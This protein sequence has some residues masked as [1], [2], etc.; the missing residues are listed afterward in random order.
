MKIINFYND[1]QEREK[2]LLFI[3]FVLI[4]SLVLYFI[5]SGVHS[6]YTRSS[7]NLEKAKSDY[8]YVLNKIQRIQNSY[9][10][11]VLDKNVITKL[12]SSNNFENKVNNLQISST[13]KLIYVTFTTSNINDA[14]SVT[15]K[16][17]NGS[18]NQISNIRYQQ[19]DKQ[20][21]TQLIFN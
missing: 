10:K 8:E 18:L 4:I 14:V 1:L 12:I 17:M 2:K 20:I 13:D 15:E 6:N 3:S 7:L 19:S 5:F 16:L 11:N 21:N 9:D